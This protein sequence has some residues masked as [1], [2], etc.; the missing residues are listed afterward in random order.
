MFA[1]EMKSIL[2]VVIASAAF[3]GFAL[4]VYNCFLELVRSHPRCSVR[5]RKL[6]RRIKKQVVDVGVT[7][8]A[9]NEGIIA[10]TV[11]EVYLL[12]RDGSRLAPESPGG[13]DRVPKVVHPGE[14]CEIKIYR[15]DDKNAP[16]LGDVVR[17][18]FVISSGKEFRSKKL[19]DGME[20]D[21]IR[22][23]LPALRLLSCLPLSY[24]FLVVFVVVVAVR[25]LWYN[26][27]LCKTLHQTV[28][29]EK[30]RQP[31]SFHGRLRFATT[32][33]RFKFNG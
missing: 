14:D 26:F 13:R 27:R 9:V 22:P 12:K 3:G 28:R 24:P 29:V 30:Q 7:A 15:V 23:V 33:N 5:V 31:P 25:P 6:V 2:D 19:P 18:V 20:G 32:V 21:F 4:S 16:V 10:F 8:V 17:V 1:M 11:S